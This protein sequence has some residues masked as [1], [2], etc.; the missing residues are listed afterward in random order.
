M[1][2]MPQS[3][4]SRINNDAES[5]GEDLVDEFD[6]PIGEDGNQYHVIERREEFADILVEIIQGIASSE[7]TD[8]EG[9]VRP[10]ADMLDFLY[11]FTAVGA[12]Q[13]RFSLWD[14]RDILL[15]SRQKLDAG[16]RMTDLAERSRD[17]QLGEHGPR[18]QRG[19]E[20]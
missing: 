3:S 17:N 19:D 16:E 7:F 1:T 15:R 10:D 9:R 5:E 18:R 2:W 20:S 12:E 8:D 13:Y 4:I 11:T 14:M 6:I